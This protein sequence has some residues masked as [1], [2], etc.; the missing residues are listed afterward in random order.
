[1]QTLRALGSWIDRHATVLMA[2]AT[3]L[4]AAAF[5]VV[6]IIH[7]LGLRTQLHD[8]GHM[9]QSIWDV[10]HGY[11]SMPN[12]DPIPYQSRFFVHA[13]VIFYLLAPL[14]ALLP[15]PLTLLLLGAL[16]VASAGFLLYLFA[17]HVLGNRVIALGFGVAY[18]LNPLVQ[19]AVLF[20]FRADLLAYPL[21]ILVIFAALKRR[22]PAYWVATILLLSVKE[23]MAFLVA[24]IG[25]FLL[26]RK[27]WWHGG[28]TVAVGILYWVALGAIGDLLGVTLSGNAMARFAYLGDGPGSMAVTAI[29]NPSMVFDVLAKRMPYVAY[30]VLQGGFLAIFSP[31]ALLPVLPN[32]LQ[33]VLDASGFQARLI[34]TYHSGIVMTL[35][36]LAAVQGAGTVRRRWPHIFP[37]IFCLF[38]FQA[39]VF[40]AAFGPLPYSVTTDAVDLRIGHD[41]A[42]FERM[43][44]FIPPDASLATQNNLGAHFAARRDIFEYPTGMDRAEYVLF[45]IQDPTNGSFHRFRKNARM[46]LDSYSLNLRYGTRVQHAFENPNFGLVAQESSFYLFKRGA[47]RDANAAAWETAKLELQ[48]LAPVL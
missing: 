30:V 29:T 5:G 10:V 39:V 40:S 4:A 46:L 21:S 41:R 16:A 2:I 34:G 33:N 20:D 18:L 48:Q 12:S 6:G 17:S 31:A 13:N 8:L 7:H 44:A 19:E 11:W 37:W 32:L 36:A 9:E 43:K 38:L 26:C 28:V 42:A 35:L 25:I 1:M 24:A 3:G 45:H 23:D 27:Q 22:W 14:Y 47:P 15:S